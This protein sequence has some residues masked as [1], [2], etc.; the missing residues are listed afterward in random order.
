MGEVLSHGTHK[1]GYGFL[2]SL[3]SLGLST[4][5]IYILSSMKR[6]ARNS[7][8]SWVIPSRKLGI[9]VGPVDAGILYPLPL[10]FFY[11]SD[12]IIS[13]QR[14][15]TSRGLRPSLAGPLDHGGKARRVS[16]GPG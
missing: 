8:G 3:A 11:P 6:E 10:S 5:P 2:A 14:L 1:I 12:P 16:L 13:A 9:V 7:T 15:P 4:W